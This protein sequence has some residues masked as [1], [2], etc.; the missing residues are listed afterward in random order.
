MKPRIAIIDTGI[1]ADDSRDKFISESYIVKKNKQTYSIVATPTIDPIG[2]GSAIFDI[3]QSVNPRIEV[4]SIRLCENELHAVEEKALLVAL[5]FLL[6]KIS[7]DIINISAGITYS[8]F[9]KQLHA[10]C[11]KLWQRGVIIVSA[12]D[13]DGAISYPAAFDEVIG[14]DL[15][16]LYKPQDAIHVSDKGIVNV[17][18]PEK[19]YRINYCG[20]KTLIKG[21]SF[22]AAYVTGLISLR[23]NSFPLDITS[24]LKSISNFNVNIEKSKNVEKPI[25]KT[26]KAIIFPINKESS[27]L[28]RY[29]DLV[30]FDIVGVYDE[31]FSGRIG[32]S[33][34]GFTV[35]SYDDI[36]WKSDFDTIILSCTSALA[37][38]TKRDYQN[39]VITLATQNGKNIYS[40][41]PIPQAH[42]VFFPF[43]DRKSVPFENLYKRHQ[44][45]LPIVGVWGTSSKQGKFSLQLELI[46]RL[47]KMGY[48]TGH[49][50][51]EPSGYL[52]DADKVFN[53]GYG[54]PLEVEP[55][56]CTVLLDQMIWDIQNSEKD[57]LITGGQSGA[58]QYYNTSV[59][60]FTSYQYA[61]MLG[62]CPDFNILCINPHDDML[63]IN[64]TIDLIKSSTE[65]P[66]SAIVVYP[67]EIQET[68]SGVP[69][70]KR[71]LLPFEQD[72]FCKKT[73]N[74]IQIPTYSLFKHDDIDKLCNQIVQYFSEH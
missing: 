22:A 2:H 5:E 1:S 74:T 50:S 4:I 6:E 31:R 36:D 38:I 40:F 56:E 45:T 43:I 71:E 16:R 24:I 60:K 27:A 37:G 11:K 33:F 17:F 70:R 13:N 18:V 47:R 28:L 20:T 53:F 57:I 19:Y 51:T 54:A 3:I 32:K 34:L 7:L 55:W 41:E 21:T 29:R 58:L 52:F 44:N 39:D 15:N 42:N 62:T 67:I 49:I 46:R 61:Y 23:K 48:K 68:I 30:N 14:V 59:E 65:N 35:Q 12:F 72:T 73:T 10:V 63:Y 26:K 64:R 9:N 69:Y 8:F 66:I 25:F